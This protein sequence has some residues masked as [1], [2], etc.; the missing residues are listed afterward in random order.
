MDA[1]DNFNLP[2]PSILIAENAAAPFFNPRPFVAAVFIMKRHAPVARNG[3]ERVVAYGYDNI[4][5]FQRREPVM[6]PVKAGPHFAFRDSVN[7]R[8]LALVPAIR[9]VKVVA[10][11]PRI[12]QPRLQLI[13]PT[14][15]DERPLIRLLPMAV[16]FAD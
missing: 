5:V 12:S 7:I 1:W 16:G 2:P 6:Q 15:A 4:R 11:Q 10:R 14:R 8:R 13:R 3:I 9:D